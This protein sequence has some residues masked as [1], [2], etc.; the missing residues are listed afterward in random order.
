MIQMRAAAPLVL[1]AALFIG[2]SLAQQRFAPTPE[3]VLQTARHLLESGRPADALQALD[4][5]LARNR[6]AAGLEVAVFRIEAARAAIAALQPEV[7]RVHTV[8][9]GR[10]IERLRPQP[11]LRAR[12]QREIA[13]LHERLGDPRQAE[14][15][16]RASVEGLRTGDSAAA[17]EAA[18][19]LGAVLIDLGRPRPA[20]LALQDS[21]NLLSASALTGEPVVSAL[22]NMT[23]AYLEDAQIDRARDA[24]HRARLAA[25]VDPNLLR[26]ADFAEAQL[27]LR[28]SRLTGAERLLDAIAR[29]ERGGLLRAHGLQL[30]ATSRFNRGRHPEAAEAAFAALEAY[31]TIVG[32]AHPAFGRALHTLG[33]I[34]AELGASAAA[35]AFLERAAAVAT[36]SFGAQAI[37]AHLSQIEI[38]AIE[39][40]EPTGVAAAER[41]ARAALRAFQR[42]GMPDRRPEALATVVLGLVA[43]RRDQTDTAAAAFRRAQSIL[44]VA[45]GSD[46]P[47]LGFSLVRLGR[48][49]TT[50]FRF[51]EAAPPLDRAIALY[52][53]LGG[54]GT[55]RLADALTAR[56]ELRARAGDRRGALDQIRR[57]H[58]LLSD[59]VQAGESP[60]DSEETQRRGS[61]AIFAA[62]ATLLVS[63]QDLHPGALEEAFAASQESLTSRAGEALRLSTIRLMAGESEAASLIRAQSAAADALRQTD[64]LILHSSAERGGGVELPRLRALR[65]DQASALAETRRGFADRAPRL[66]AFLQP[67]PVQ[68]A[69][70]RASLDDDEAL[71]APVVSDEG[72]LL[73]VITRGSAYATPVP[74]SRLGLSVLVNRI[75]DTLDTAS[76]SGPPAFD[77]DAAKTIYAALVTPAEATGALARASHIVIVPDGA[78]Q[79]LPP[80]LL[81]SEDGEWLVRRY[82]TTIAPS[83]ASFASSRQAARRP[84]SAP[85][86]LLGIGNPALSGYAADGAASRG[87]PSSLRDGLSS[88]SPLPDTETELRALAEVLGKDGSSLLLGV[89]ATEQRL[90]NADPGQYRILAFATH[91]VMAGEVPGLSEPA[92]ILTPDGADSPMEGLLT[93]SDVAAMELDADLIL[94]SA[95]NTAAPEAGPYSEGLS[96][97]A[98]AFL[99]AGARRILVSHWAVNSV[100]AARL[101]TAFIVARQEDPSGRPAASLRTSILRNMRAE[102]MRHPAYW[103]PFVL[104]GS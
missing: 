3:A 52:E 7:A 80:H 2:P 75:R 27:A 28:E 32:E 69:D 87:I 103:A 57:A 68:L 86:A 26:I 9:A 16:L 82:A 94:L 81:Q 34:Q 62:Q 92:V 8:A 39:V 30:L 21:L 61:Q 89:D 43:E 96:G 49:L 5:F 78:L 104:V 54:A 35:M 46:S 100:A 40:R 73:W 58:A 65:V 102:E 47:D 12:F 71:L 45:R 59:R 63:L 10:I 33:T 101:T 77:A 72:C 25:D 98:R 64:A 84:S 85:L 19:A 99:Q 18:N 95:C 29:D 91:A 66:V 48:L 51:A 20:V 42:S 55:V 37:Q 41:R 70:V 83:M 23:N 93:A 76:A 50:A 38:A 97:L 13:R 1:L 53:R 6:N 4:A 44:E 56:A 17:A 15:L 79:R 36:A 11:V 74:L 24:A 90:A 31:R 60:G 88:L 22:A 14:P 67:R